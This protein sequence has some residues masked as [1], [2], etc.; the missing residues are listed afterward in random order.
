MTKLNIKTKIVAATGVLHL[1]DETGAKM[2]AEGEGGGEP[3]PVTVTVYGPGSK[4]FL[5][6]QAE[7]ENRILDRMA[8][9]VNAK[10]SES[11]D[12]KRERGAKFLADTTAG[13]EN[14]D[15]DGKTGRD[16]ALAIYGEPGLG[17]IAE[18]VRKFQGSWA[19]F[20]KGSTKP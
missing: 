18:Q 3:Q 6:A 14:I 7:N 4:E 10:D 20:S 1:A 11:I 5:K 9:G 19:N 17:Y 2:Y 15:F 12:Q 8:S 13:F 16:L